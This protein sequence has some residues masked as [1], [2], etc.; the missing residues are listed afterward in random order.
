MPVAGDHDRSTGTG[1]RDDAGPVA[2]PRA[3]VPVRAACHQQQISQQVRALSFHE[4]CECPPSDA[5]PVH[6]LQS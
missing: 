6:D 2:A 1:Y 3:S 5:C 4:A